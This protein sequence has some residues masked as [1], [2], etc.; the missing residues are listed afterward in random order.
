MTFLVFAIIFSTSI[1][2]TFRLFKTYSIDN[3]QAITINYLVAALIGYIISPVK[4]S[5]E[6]IFQAAW[7]PFSIIVGLLFIIGFYL[8]AVSS[9]K[10]GVS[11]T[12]VASKMSIIIPIT[13]GILLYEE[14]ISALK[15]LGIV[16]AI[17]S[18]YLTL[19][20]D[21]KE[22]LVNKSVIIL[23]ILLFFTSGTIDTSLK[24]AVNIHIEDDYMLYLST[25]FL[26]SLLFGLLISAFQKKRIKKINLQ[27][28][29]G[30][31]ILGLIN[32]GTV[33]YMLR[34]MDQFESTTQFP[35]QNISIVVLS[36]L[37]GFI[38]FKERLKMINLFGIAL[39][40]V[41]IILVS[42]F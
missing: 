31:V 5:F 11:L 16:T 35:I 33:Y 27:T 12:A 20:G 2:V 23:P 22:K 42:I 14:S 3:H 10:A 34:A 25:V 24:Y 32:F 6:N 41:S 38:G 21:R 29:L 15:L 19:K 17:L 40:I 28:I 37:V 13:V 26:F 30:G 8:F 18:L 7:L 36:A 9:Q 4:P 39:S 1:F